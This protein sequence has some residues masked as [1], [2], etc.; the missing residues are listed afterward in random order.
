MGFSY[1]SRSVNLILAVTKR[2]L[3]L[4][5]R[6]RANYFS[7]VLYTAMWV[8]IAI[9]FVQTLNQ[10][11]ISQAI[12]STNYAAFVLLG[13][14]VA[15]Y[16]GTALQGPSSVLQGEVSTGQIDYT[17][18]SP[19]SRYWYVVS[20][21]CAMSVISTMFFAPMF[22]V[23]LAFT[24]FTVQVSNLLLSMADVFTMILALVQLG[25]VFSG[26]ALLYK[27]ISAFFGFLNFF[28]VFF[29][30]TFIPL[31][32]FPSLMQLVGFLV[33]S[34]AGMDLLRHYVLGTYT[35]IGVQQEWGILVAEL[36][37]LTFVA[38][39]SINYLERVAKRSNLNLF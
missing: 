2:E 25:V 5:T 33:P 11:Q 36:F 35:I 14:S 27:N 7:R 3:I 23:A 31:Q 10:F 21:A 24:G 16:Q 20:Y 26:L 29:T 28:F 8:I 38:K 34:A 22:V 9:L 1:L 12:G 39:V 17:F 15:D 13:V 30:G 4:L 6:Y 37:I 19:V 32:V 18:S